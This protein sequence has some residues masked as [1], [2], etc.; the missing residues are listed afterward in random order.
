M[1][2][3]LAVFSMRIFGGGAFWGGGKIPIILM[4]NMLRFR[5]TLH[6]AVI[7]YTFKR[8]KGI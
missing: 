6:F 8:I 4:T 7:K 3:G 2:S 1:K 5:L